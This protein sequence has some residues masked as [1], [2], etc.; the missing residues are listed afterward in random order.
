ML[1]TTET[2]K[3]CFMV[4]QPY[5]CILSIRSWHM[6]PVFF[7]ILHVAA[8]STSDSHKPAM[9]HQIRLAHQATCTS[10][11]NCSRS[12]EQKRAS[13]GHGCRLE[14]VS[15]C[16]Q[17]LDEAYSRCAL[18]HAKAYMSLI[19]MRNRQLPGRHRQVV[20][21]SG[22]ICCIWQR[23]HHIWS[24]SALDA[25]LPQCWGHWNQQ[26]PPKEVPLPGSRMDQGWIRLKIC[27]DTSSGIKDTFSGI[28][29]GRPFAPEAAHKVQHYNTRVSLQDL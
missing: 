1:M 6:G 5:P 10:R 15:I 27:K 25:A 19:D 16:R 14:C 3:R 26:K 28:K 9:A 7:W 21:P 20:V 23:P 2:C 22:R 24:S 8:P 13:S 11:Q 17:G 12:Q 18:M 4:D 29:E